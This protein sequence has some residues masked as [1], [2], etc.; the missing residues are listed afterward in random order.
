[1]SEMQKKRFAIIVLQ[2][3]NIILYTLL[4]PD[5]EESQRQYKLDKYYALSAEISALQIALSGIGQ[6]ANQDKP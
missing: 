3:L 6:P 2:A 1:M 4:Y 5:R